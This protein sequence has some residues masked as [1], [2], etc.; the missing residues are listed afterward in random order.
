MTKKQFYDWQT[1]GGTDDV[2]RLVDALERADI[3]W[4]AIGGLAV[5]HWADEPMVTRDVD[6]VVVAD[7]VEAAVRA[8]ETA[9]FR[10]E[11]FPWSINLKGDSAISIQVSTAAFYRD[12][13]ARA[14]PAD[15]HGILMRVAS[16]DDTLSGKIEAWRDTRRRQSK[17]IKVLGDIARLIESHPRLWERL[18]PSLAEQIDRPNLGTTLV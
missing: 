2:M 10:H 1:G 6:L 7:A 17:R 4:Y 13:P 5:N 12:F 11:R 9:G 15:A 14:V 16:L 8:L 18:P 3:S